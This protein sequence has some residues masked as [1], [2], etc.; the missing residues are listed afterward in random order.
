MTTTEISEQKIKYVQLGI[1]VGLACIGSLIHVASGPATTEVII[2]RTDVNRGAPVKYEDFGTMQIAAHLAPMN[3]LQP[4]DLK[5]I[6]YLYYRRSE[7]KDAVA[8]GDLIINQATNPELKLTAQ[9]TSVRIPLP[10]GVMPE[11]LAIG[12]LVT[13][14]I[15]TSMPLPTSVGEI[16]TSMPQ[17]TTGEAVRRLVE[18]GEFRVISVGSK[19]DR[20]EDRWESID[21][22]EFIRIAIP[23]DSPNR[24]LIESAALSAPGYHAGNARIVDI[25]TRA[26]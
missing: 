21:G 1:A 8:I 26:R 7:R 5:D 2:L 16:R 23:K 18:C 12:S 24:L 9:E 17:D 3:C 11:D 13:L 15:S 14:Q 20:L 10:V 25:F 19:Y 6:E 4:S 22:A